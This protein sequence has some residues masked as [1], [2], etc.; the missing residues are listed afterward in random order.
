MFLP[1][2][3]ILINFW[4]LFFG[5]VVFEERVRETVAGAE[6]DVVNIAGAEHTSVGEHQRVRQCV[7][8]PTALLKVSRRSDSAAWVQRIRLIQVLPSADQIHLK[9][10]GNSR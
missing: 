6:D 8:R 3:S 2:N 7:H 10:L 4:H 1:R 5:T 9:L